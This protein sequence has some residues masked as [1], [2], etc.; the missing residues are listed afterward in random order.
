MAPGPGEETRCGFVA[1][2]GAPN[3]GK[4]TL[5]NALVGSKV[6]I[7]TH[8]VQTTRARIV[9]L[10]VE[11]ASQIIFIDTPGIFLPQRRLDRAMVTAAWSGAAD[12]DLV[13]LLVDAA[14]G[15]DRDTKAIID[16]LK[17]AGRKAVLVVNKIDL[18]KRPTLLALVRDLDSE[19]IFT[20]VFMIS[21]LTGDGL[22][23]LKRHFAESIPAGP[24][25]YPEDQ[26]ADISERLL[27]ADIT[28]EQ[29]FL[30]LH[31]E[32][33]YSSTVETEAW[34]EHK[35]GSVRIQQVVYVAR[36]GQ[37]AIVLGKGGRTIKAIGAAARQEMERAFGRRVHLFI[38]V[39]VREH[40]ADDPERYREMGLDFPG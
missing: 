16:G 24:W 18:V 20:N 40:W 30:R 37:K 19:G 29:L 38:F 28:R 23:D 34:E 17:Q 22:T 7:V 14:R 6:S 1:L 10:A 21:A 5:L 4:S 32:L 3:T 8:K 25:L 36:D 33:P 11:G 27:A 9:A 31:Q 12:A 13:A 15:I 35:D 26:L 2:L 39:K